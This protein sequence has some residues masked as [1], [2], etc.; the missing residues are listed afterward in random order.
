MMKKGLNIV[1]YEIALEIGDFY[2]FKDVFEIHP[3]I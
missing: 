1:T 2:N 3:A